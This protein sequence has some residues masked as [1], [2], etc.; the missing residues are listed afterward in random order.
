MKLHLG[1]REGLMRDA[2]ATWEML[3]SVFLEL[4]LY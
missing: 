2:V 1:G 4:D 3:A